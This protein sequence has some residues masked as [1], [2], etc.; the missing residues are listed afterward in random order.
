MNNAPSVG[1][2]APA[3][4]PTALQIATAIGIFAFG[5]VCR[6]RAS[7]DGTSAAAPMACSIRAITRMATVG[8][9]PQSIEAMVNTTTAPRNVRRRPMR[10][11]R[12][13]AG[14]SMAAKTMV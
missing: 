3:T 1:P 5:K 7:E 13:P 12:R 9:R 14:M 8:A 11:A 2:S 4:A 10:S 6:I